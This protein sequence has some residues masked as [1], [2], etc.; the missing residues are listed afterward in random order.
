MLTVYGIRKE[1][2]KMAITLSTGP[3]DLSLYSFKGVTSRA[4]K[5]ADYVHSR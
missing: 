4:I 5:T 3:Q 2:E 1:I